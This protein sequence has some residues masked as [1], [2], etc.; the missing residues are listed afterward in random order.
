M[1]RGSCCFWL[2]YKKIFFIMFILLSQQAIAENSYESVK[3]LLDTWKYNFGWKTF[4]G[5]YVRHILLFT[6]SS[7]IDIET[8][9][10]SNTPA[11]SNGSFFDISKEIQ[12]FSEE[13]LIILPPALVL[14]AILKT[15]P[16]PQEKM[17][18]D[19]EKIIKQASQNPTAENF[20]KAIKM[21]FKGSEV[22]DIWKFSD[23][24]GVKVKRK[25]DEIHIKFKFNDKKH[26]FISKCDNV[27]NSK[28][29]EVI[30]KGLL[31]L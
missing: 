18:E 8:T 14:N 3:F 22:K 23:M 7:V 26:R 10:V 1:E 9:E 30:L 5:G 19:V 21:I 24:E 31:D 25:K 11:Y 27:E 2:N 17:A 20:I 6:D 28:K 13:K 29:I 4:G 16:S 12:D 15:L